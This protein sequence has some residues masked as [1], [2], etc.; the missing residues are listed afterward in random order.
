M[1][2]VAFFL[3]RIRISVMH[4]YKGLLCNKGCRYG[5]P[6]H[7]FNGGDQPWACD[8]ATVSYKQAPK[9]RGLPS[10]LQLSKHVHSPSA[11]QDWVR[12]ACALSLAC[13]TQ[14]SNSKFETWTLEKRLPFWVRVG[15][16]GVDDWWFIMKI[17]YLP[18]PNQ[19]RGKYTY[20][21]KSSW[22][23]TPSREPAILYVQR[24]H[25][26][27]VRLSLVATALHCLV[28]AL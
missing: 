22:A 11:K 19:S 28:G 4:Y 9:R 25:V 15:C 7:H 27:G 2:S 16:C 8:H 20:R 13:C 3:V 21:E 10:I 23:M 12:G 24:R 14:F 5:G 6:V 1:L 26:Y 17:I 18:A